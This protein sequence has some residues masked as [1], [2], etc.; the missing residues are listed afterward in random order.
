M[1]SP[2]SSQPATHMRFRCCLRYI[3]SVE[4]FVAISS[5][6]LRRARSWRDVFV[7]ACLAILLASLGSIPAAAQSSSEGALRGRV[8]DGTGAVLP[9]TTVTLT[10]VGGGFH[11]TVIA[12]DRG[13]YRLANVPA[14]AYELTAELAGFSIATVTGITVRA[15]VAAIVD[16]TLAPSGVQESV[17][18]RRQTPLLESDTA[19]RALNLSGETQR[20][21]P[22]SS[23]RAW[24]DAMFL[25]PGAVM[26]ESGG[27]ARHIFHVHGSD[28]D[29]NVMQVDG[30]DVGPAVQALQ[31]LTNLSDTTIEDVQ[32]KTA[33]V[34]ASSPLG[35]GAVLNVAAKRGTNH[36]SGE[37]SLVVQPSVWIGNNLPGGTPTREELV[38]FDVA[39]GGPLQRDRWWYFGSL[40][41]QDSQAGVSRTASDIA[42]LAALAPDFQP[43]DAAA[44]GTFYFA[45]ITGQL[46]ANHRVSGFYQ[47]DAHLV[48]TFGPRSTDP[49]LSQ[50]GGDAVSLR[51][52]SVLGG[53]F[54][55]RLS[56][57]YNN[58]T[59]DTRMATLDATFRSVFQTVTVSS[60][61]AG[62]V[63]PLAQFGAGSSE[64]TR[65]AKKLVIAADVT[66]SALRFLGEHELKAGVYSQPIT[67]V[68]SYD[69]YVAGGFVREDL[70][71]V[72]PANP[73]GGVRPFRQ[74]FND[75][76][77]LETQA[78][79]T[80]DNAIYVQDTWRPMPSLTIT[81]G[82]RADWVNRRDD[83][84][85]LDTQSSLDL[86]PRFGVSYLLDREAKTALRGSWGRLHELVEKGAA[87]YS[88]Q[89]GTRE[90][91]DTNGDGVFDQTFITPASNTQTGNREIDLD[92]HQ[93]YVNE[94]TVSL[95]RQL[96][97]RTTVEVGM[98]GR[99]YRD[100]WALVEIN[101]LYSPSNVFLGYRDLSQNEIYRV[102]NNDWNRQATNSFEVNVSHQT[103]RLT[104]LAN[105]A[106]QWRH[107]SGTWQPRD[108]AA[109]LQPDAFDNSRGIGITAAPV[110]SPSESNSLSGTQGAQNG[111]NS[112]WQDHVLQTA[113]AV[114][115]PFGLTM[116]A[117][118][119]Y[120]SGP[121]SGPIITRV[122]PD[123]SYGPATVTLPNGRVVSN[124]L[125]TAFRF[126]GVNRTDQQFH[127][128]AIHIV[129]A[130]VGYRLPIRLKTEVLLDVFNVANG[131]GDFD[132][133]AGGHQTFSPNYQKTATRQRAR[134]GQLSFRVAF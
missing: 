101:G 25:T 91:H 90:L 114:Q 17:V 33:A 133:M 39:A 125:A 31:Y 14:G 28:I 124:P 1:R 51:L 23:R 20:A 64:S 24:S 50:R 21:L 65:P 92:R 61:R 79:Q 76:T 7:P 108:P 3:W 73:A 83:L 104:A 49:S 66:K 94:W 100:R 53:T 131:D 105:Y 85:G 112:Q 71:L 12:D 46:G 68:R 58:K 43:R 78:V 29:A 37:A 10:A 106:R 111:G 70:V 38:L 18:V 8:S 60:G 98:V 44:D 45:K 77:E 115:G 99:E 128:P 132:I 5:R 117:S 32:V 59:V 30:A 87:A 84:F 48:E 81:A 27:G 72:N 109:I 122:T 42:N 19:L 34:D 93:P 40:R 126:A 110:S 118:Y 82:L 88:R 26:K 69:R 52:D 35:L 102:T 57:S 107:M 127:V 6:E 67:S 116:A 2:H 22:L 96:P 86:G 56:V 119:Q 80:S 9:G 16:L 63:T 75:D 130:R 134:S 62:G 4:L 13:A 123:L 36:L 11:Q 121:W 15:G 113:A 47:R 89:T 129:N 54:L 103:G 55:G 41:R 97:A 120:Q 74:V 95:R